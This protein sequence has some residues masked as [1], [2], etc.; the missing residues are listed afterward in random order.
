MQS[1]MQIP[2]VNREISKVIEKNNEINSSQIIDSLNDYKTVVEI[3]QSLLICLEQADKF[4]KDNV[5][6]QQEPIE[7]QQP[8]QQENNQSLPNDFLDEF[9]NPNNGWSSGPEKNIMMMVYTQLN[10]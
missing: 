10:I 7:Q 6:K 4:I 5:G 3:K 1:Y 9:D 2:K 8:V